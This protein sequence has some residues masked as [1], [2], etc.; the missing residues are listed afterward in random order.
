[1]PAAAEGDERNLGAAK[2][3]RLEEV[4]DGLFRKRHSDVPR[5]ADVRQRKLD[6]LVHDTAQPITLPRQCDATERVAQSVRGLAASWLLNSRR[7]AHFLLKCHPADF[8]MPN[9]RVKPAPTVWRAGP[10]GENVPRTA[11]RARVTRRWGSA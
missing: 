7:Q 10:V 5:S 4:T 2:G 9:V 8:L 11:E 3:G 1:M 6:Q